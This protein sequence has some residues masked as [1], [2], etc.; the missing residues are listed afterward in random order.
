MRAPILLFGKGSNGP[1]GV[2]GATVLSITTSTERS[3][4]SKRRARVERNRLAWKRHVQRR[5]PKPQTAHQYDP[6]HRALSQWPVLGRRLSSIHHRPEGKL[7]LNKKPQWK[8]NDIFLHL[9]IHLQAKGAGKTCT[10]CLPDPTGA[11]K[12]RRDDVAEEPSETSSE[13]SVTI[14]C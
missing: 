11:P 7:N 9:R 3:R 4:S 5:S 1:C 8:K 2:E 10:R 14:S 6:V 12:L 13:P